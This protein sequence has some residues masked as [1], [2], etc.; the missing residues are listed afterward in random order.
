MECRE[1][2][3]RLEE[4]RREALPARAREEVSV[5]LD[6]CRRCQALHEA[7]LALARALRFGLPRHSAPPAL[8]RRIRQVTGQDPR[9]FAFLSNP[10]VS[11]GAAAGLTLILLLPFLL[12]GRSDTM[13]A[14]AA[15]VM[16]EHLRTVLAEEVEGNQ[17]NYEALVQRLRAKTGVP[18]R[19]FYAGDPEVKLVYVRPVLVLGKK[20]VGLVYQ[21]QT[22][23]T[24]TYLVFPGEEVTVP[25]TGRVQV[26]DYKPYW[27]KT[28][29]YSLLLWKQ[30]GLN[31]VLVSDWD[32]ERFLQLFLNVRRAAAPA[33]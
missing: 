7:D 5:H 28:D 11:A 29:G 1:V 18:L 10:W 16:S 4:F 20:G 30:D 6:Q 15:E 8:R 24:A 13:Q 17:E 14:L 19:W 26:A 9:R 33:L 25:S 22:G 12:R 3:E 32:R 21:D 27:G 2:Q 31:R 23:R